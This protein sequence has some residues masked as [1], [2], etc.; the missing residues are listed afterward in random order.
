MPT[1]RTRHAVT[2]TDEITEILDEAAR[3]WP[4]VPRAR[5]IRLVMLDW[6]RGG[7]SPSTRAQIRESLIGSLPGSSN[8]YDR[9]EDW[10][11]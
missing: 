4:D 8:L 9:A 7:R 6:F 5:L 11:A 10:P 3:R 2:E 1:T